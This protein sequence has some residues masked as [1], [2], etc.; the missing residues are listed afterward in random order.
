MSKTVSLSRAKI[1]TRLS[2]SLRMIS[3]KRRILRFQKSRSSNRNMI[4]QWTSSL[5]AKLTSKEKRLLR[6]KDCRSRNKESR[7]IMNKCNRPS[8]DMKRDSSKR[9]KMLRKL[10]MRESQES[11]KRRKALKPSMSRRERHS[12]S[13]R[14]T[15][16]SLPHRMRE[17]GL[18]RLR[19]IRAWRRD[20]RTSLLVS[21]L[22][23][24]SFKSKMN[25]SMRPYLRENSELENKLS[26]GRANTM[27]WR[28]STLTF[29]VNS[30]KKKLCGR[31]NSSS[32]RSRRIRPRKTT[33]SISKTSKLLSSSFRNLSKRVNQSMITIKA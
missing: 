10:S 33:R 20:S 23:T 15:S 28:D 16:N 5:K 7:S 24:R 14:R 4:N 17:K 13:S 21:N 27:R 19:S 32:L 30:R 18:F 26:T 9:K 3:P 25:S 6:I 22:R 29:K 31:A 8:K 12:R 11:S 1:K 2:T